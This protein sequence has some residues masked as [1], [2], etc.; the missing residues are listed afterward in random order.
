[1]TTPYH[2]EQ[3]AVNFGDYGPPDYDPYADTRTRTNDAASTYTHATSGILVPD[4]SVKKNEYGQTEAEAVAHSYL[5]FPPSADPSTSRQS[6]V[7]SIDRRTSNTSKYRKSFAPSNTDALTYIDEEGNYYSNR[8]KYN[9]ADKSEDS[10]VHNA[11]D[12]GENQAPR[13]MT[14]LGELYFQLIIINLL[15]TQSE[16]QDPYK[17]DDFSAQPEPKS[18]LERFLNSGIYPLEQR[19][20]NKK[21]GIGRQR[22]PFV[23]E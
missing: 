12:M 22:Y 17:R 9:L 19:I 10:L 15:T 8:K 5:S 6:R 13:S 23:G 4:D 3:R 16:Y 18:G 11:A 21:R 2:Y 20:E 7:S 14:D 1:M